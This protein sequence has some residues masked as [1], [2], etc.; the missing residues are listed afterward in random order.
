MLSRR[1]VLS[2]IV[3]SDQTPSFTHQRAL[4]RIMGGV[5]THCGHLGKDTKEALFDVIYIT[6]RR[7]TKHLLMLN[8]K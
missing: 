5:G 4:N 7:I 1:P 8:S 6:K 3:F 2:N